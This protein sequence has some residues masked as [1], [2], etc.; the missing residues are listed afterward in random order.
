MLHTSPVS[1]GPGRGGV[2]EAAVVL[3]GRRTGHAAV[4]VPQRVEGLD[5]ALCVPGV[6]GKIG[7]KDLKIQIQT[8]KKDLDLD[9]DPFSQ[10]G[11]FQNGSGSKIWIYLVVKRSY[12]KGSGTVG[13]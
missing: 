8:L 3:R 1:L 13:S 6:V 4:A 10:S 5:A 2:D 12:Q 11:S 9:L 7:S